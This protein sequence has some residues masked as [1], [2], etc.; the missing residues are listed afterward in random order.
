MFLHIFA[1]DRLKRPPPDAQINAELT[2]T[3]LVKLM[4]Q[5]VGEVEPRGGRCDGAARLRLG[6]LCIHRLIRSPILL[7]SNLD[8]T[9]LSRTENVRRQRSRADLFQRALHVFNRRLRAGPPTRAILFYERQRDL[10]GLVVMIDEP[11]DHSFL[12]FP[13]AFEQQFPVAVGHRFEK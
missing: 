11:D 8:P 12:K 3:L 9:L 6:R 7:V 2:D 1:L 5:I 10:A 13:I 4:K